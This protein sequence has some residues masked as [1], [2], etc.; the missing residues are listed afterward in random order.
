MSITPTFNQKRQ[1]TFEPTTNILGYPITGG[2][3]TGGETISFNPSKGQFEISDGLVRPFTTNTFYGLD[4]T[5]AAITTGL[6]NTAEGASALEVVTTGDGNTGIG[7][8]ALTALTTG[9]NNVAVGFN[10]GSVYTTESGN[11][12]LGNNGVV[13]DAG[14]M[15]LGNVNTL[16]TYISGIS[17]KTTAGGVDVL[18]N[19]AG[20][21]GTVVSSQRF[22]ENI[23]DAKDYSPIVDNLRVVNFTYKSDKDSLI[24]CGLIAEEVLDVLPELVVM[25]ADGV[26]PGTVVYRTLI[27]ILLQQVQILK[28]QVQDLKE[29]VGKLATSSNLISL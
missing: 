14:V 11:I 19:T 1:T 9:D 3:P 25:E 4:S 26:T 17:G 29:Q 24:Q 12:L 6:N 27:P 15:R 21:L 8:N 20:L 22:K 18:I 28:A 7:S 13:S 23:V 16:S 5:G 2:P 10:S